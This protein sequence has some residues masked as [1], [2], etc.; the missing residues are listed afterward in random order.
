MVY[1]KFRKTILMRIG[2]CG[3]FNS[4]KNAIGGQ[5]IKTRII[6]DELKKVYGEQNI[7]IVDTSDWK[8]KPIK[9]F[10]KSLMLAIK[11]KHIII[12]P[13]QNGIKVF[14]PLFVSLRKIFKLK[15]HYIVVG[16]WL[17]DELQKNKWLI[18]KMNKIDY[19]YV[20]TETLKTNLMKIVTNKRI[21]VFKNFKSIN[22]I[23][24]TEKV[25]EFKKDFLSVCIL[26]RINEKKGVSDAIQV[27]N[28]INEN[29]FEKKIYLDIY[30]PIEKTYKIIFA[31]QL[32]NSGNEVKY[33]G[34]LEYDDTV[35][36]IKNY[37]LLLFPTKYYTEGFP[38]TIVDSFLAGVPV[39]AS[40][41]ESHK[42]VIDENITGIT[43]AFNDEIDFHRK[44]LFLL[45]N[46]NKLFK[47]RN[48]CI[49][50]AKE[51]TSSEAIK[52]I[53]RNIF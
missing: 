39:L 42:D 29:L 12:L 50:K 48:N 44:L 32:K 15:V 33:K 20:Q 37:D 51:Y 31:E 10:F 22:P 34:I 30:G 46:Q 19:I 53:T 35:K 26:S 45:Q 11:S 5:T 13:A 2:V 7:S 6:T 40:K 25:S 27:V 43:F 16:A 28:R 14:I 36:T 38:G 17:K 18:S 21:I 41:W 3:H 47:L 52:I 9:L 8:K 23:D 4:G 49:Q 1:S 24:I